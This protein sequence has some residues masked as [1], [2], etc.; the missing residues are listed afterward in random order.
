MRSLAQRGFTNPFPAIRHSQ[1]P[2][3]LEAFA[4]RPFHRCAPE[5]PGTM[6]PSPPNIQ[7]LSSF[8]TS[9]GVSARGPPAGGRQITRNRA[10]YSCHMC[11]RRKVKCDKVKFSIGYAPVRSANN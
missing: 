1:I 9:G 4:L 8:S 2:L 7:S 10:S 6:N 5:T 11:R 3:D